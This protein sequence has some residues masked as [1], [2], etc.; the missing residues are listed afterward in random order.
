MS[1][2]SRWFGR[3]APAGVAGEALA[4]WRATPVPGEDRPADAARLV[5]VD[6]ESSGLDPARDRLLAIGAVAL[7]GGALVLAQSFEIVVQ[8]SDASGVD[9]ILVH[10]IGGDAQRTGAPPAAALAAFLDFARRD[11][12]LA[13]HAPFDRTLIERAM[14]QHLGLRFEATWLDLAWLAPAVGG[15]RGDRKGA[16]DDWLAAFGIEN[17]ERHNALADAAAT[18]QLGLALMAQG[19][20]RGVSTVQELRE[21][22]DAQRWLGRR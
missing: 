13:F 11:P 10:G 3:E 1:W 14:H 5:V 9:N 20:A 19:L 18:A 7:E 16:L 2:W 4:R 8:Q 15:E 21:A 22:A 17:V 12:L 6:V